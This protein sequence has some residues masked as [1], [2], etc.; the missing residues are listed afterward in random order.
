MEEIVYFIRLILKIKKYEIK[1]F[2]YGRHDAKHKSQGTAG[3]QAWLLL[4]TQMFKLQMVEM[5]THPR[6]IHL[7][8]MTSV[9]PALN[10]VKNVHVSIW[11]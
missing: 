5:Q 9:S 7:H 11:S 4:L 3:K 1:S 8:Q 2:S 6:T 10:R